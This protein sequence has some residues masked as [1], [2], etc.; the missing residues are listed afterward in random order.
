MCRTE[1]FVTREG[2]SS[3]DVTLVRTVNIIRAT[4]RKLTAFVQNRFKVPQVH[5]RTPAERIQTWVPSALVQRESLRYKLFGGPCHSSSMLCASGMG[6][7]ATGCEVVVSDKFRAAR[8]RSMKFTDGLH[9]SFGS[10]GS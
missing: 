8:A 5:R 2:Y 9:Y 7:D 1:R 3:C 6:S 10:T 4:R